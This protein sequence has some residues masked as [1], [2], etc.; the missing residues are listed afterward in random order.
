LLEA[1]DVDF[2]A[3]VPDFDG[4][5]LYDEVLEGEDEDEDGEYVEWDG[6]LGF[7]G[8]G[9]EG[10]FLG[11]WE[12]TAEVQVREIA[13]VCACEYVCVLCGCRGVCV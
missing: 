3:G 13:C 7:G 12:E 11:P 6:G 8:F 4:F 5:P 10:E 2:A 9:F 1:V